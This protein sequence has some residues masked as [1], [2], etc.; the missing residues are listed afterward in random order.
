MRECSS[1][2][3]DW[4][5]YSFRKRFTIWSFS[6]RKRLSFFVYSGR[7]RFSIWSYWDEC[8]WRKRSVVWGKSA[9][10]CFSKSIYRIVG[11]R[12]KRCSIGFHAW[13]QR[14]AI[15]SNSWRHRFS[16]FIDGN[17]CGLWKFLSVRCDAIWK[18]FSV[19]SYGV[20]LRGSDWCA[21][22]SFPRWER[23][24]FFVNSW[25]K[26]LSSLI[27]SI[28]SSSRKRFSIGSSIVR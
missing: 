19:R 7:K 27:N 13:R 16:M 15:G 12:R 20:I 26:W 6:R 5:I 21:I 8:S 4:I 17:L 9:F 23:F 25:R 3:S 28:I 2:R 22:W 14:I 1:I 11:S 10:N 18:D 24:S